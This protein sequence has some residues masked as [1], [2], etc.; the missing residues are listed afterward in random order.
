MRFHF[1]QT[2]R[3]ERLIKAISIYT[4]LTLAISGATGAPAAETYQGYA[5]G[6]S[7]NVDGPSLVLGSTETTEDYVFLLSCSNADKVAE[8]SVYVD[9]PDAQVGQAI[10]IEFSRDGVKA[11]VKGQTTTDEMSGFVFAEAKN[12][13]VKPIILMLRGEGPV[14]VVTGK[15]ATALPEEGRGSQVSQ[16]ADHCQLE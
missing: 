1:D 14:T 7:D 16:F 9:I 6:F 2:T 15:T 3:I 8:M 4:Y 10:N 5:W 11:S 12:F 13:A